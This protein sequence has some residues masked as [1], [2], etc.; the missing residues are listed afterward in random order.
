M[1]LS[2]LLP[3]DAQCIPSL[4]KVEHAIPPH[5]HPTTL[6]F[7]FNSLISFLILLLMHSN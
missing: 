5:R 7:Q 6:L 1:D 4:E 2:K 3:K